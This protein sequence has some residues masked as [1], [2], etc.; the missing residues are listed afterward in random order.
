MIPVHLN[1]YG[2]LAKLGQ[3]GMSDVYLAISRGPSD[4]H[5]LI[6]IKVL[7]DELSQKPRHVQMFRD[8]AKLT[9]RLNHPNLVQ[10]YEVGEAA[11]HH[12]LAMEYLE[13]HSLAQI[14][15]RLRKVG[16]LPLRHAL[17]IV[18]D[19]LE[20]LGYAHGLSDYDGRPLGIVHRDATPQNIFVTYQGAVKVVDF[21]IAQA[22]LMTAPILS[23]TVSGKNAYMAPE[24]ARGER[25]D[26]RADIFTMGVVLWELTTGERLWP[27]V[28]DLGWIANL[29]ASHIPEPTPRRHPLPAKLVSLCMAALSP[30]PENRPQTAREFQ[31]EL[32]SIRHTLQEDP[33]DLAELVSDAFAS[34]RRNIQTML[35]Q[36]L[37]RHRKYADVEPSSRVSVPDFAKVPQL[38]EG[39]SIHEAL[40]AVD[41]PR[42]YLH[43]NP[44]SSGP[45]PASTTAVAATVAEPN[46]PR[47]VGKAGLPGWTVIAAILGAGALA[48]GVH[49]ALE[50]FGTPRPPAFEKPTASAPTRL[51]ESN[52]G[53][54]SARTLE[55]ISQSRANKPLIELS[56]DVSED[57]SLSPDNDYL[58]RFTTQ[59]L[60]GA[61]LT[62][63]KGTTLHGDIGTKGVLVVLPGGKLEASGTREEPIV[64]TSNA[65]PGQ[66]KS[67]DWGGLILLGKAPTNA[68]AREVQL[69]IEGL[70]RGGEY[71]G[72]DP[73][74]S[75]GTLR[76][77]RIEYSGQE[78]AP[79][80]EI[81]GLSLGGVGRGTTLDHILVRN[82]ADDCFEFFGGTV[83]AK[84]LACQNPGDDAFDWD[85][86]Y[87]GRMQFLVA[88]ASPSSRVGS[89]GFEGD[90]DPGATRAKPISR[91]EIWNATLC[92]K[93]RKF[94]G[95][96]NGLLLRRGTGAV[97][98]NSIFT[99]FATGLDVR[100]SYTAPD[101]RSSVFYGN[102]MN[103][104]ARPEVQ[105]SSDPEL[106]DDD[107][108]FDEIAFLRTDALNNTDSS[109]GISDC[110]HPTAP[111]FFPEGT[112]PQGAR[113]PHDGFFDGNANF[114]GAMRGS[115]DDW[116]IG[117]WAEFGR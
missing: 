58:L 86:G 18:V 109:A 12:Y 89:N 71:G 94:S 16:G 101:I 112:A 31:R 68:S 99:G 45:N 91:P 29:Q 13:G 44:S 43:T 28:V 11:G 75:S 38:G 57:F 53:D 87:S 19:A 32:E 33:P 67:G 84:Y 98:G 26:A 80:N 36:A 42:A 15:E 105:T 2:I 70:A 50:T 102:T 96:H 20:G 25:L 77:V 21:G 5:K 106:R 49:S 111:K 69:K 117:P 46:P 83:D 82:T 100:D 60:P 90:N 78:I 62:I 48:G 97:V 85:Y 108:F 35:D 113:P 66:R 8:E 3:G 24:Q 64:F 110:F 14:S 51:A 17:G 23:G 116:L 61:T 54:A 40:T 59:V 65:P 55:P 22:S 93:N 7:R 63:P 107:S 30:K 9:A 114:R 74:D 27:G 115:S 41:T 6:V 39:S 88:Q 79:N 47:R 103:T 56:G 76:F 37:K 1:Q 95:E 10:S 52:L 92:G 81:N 104:W 34:E 73:N 4:F 72:S